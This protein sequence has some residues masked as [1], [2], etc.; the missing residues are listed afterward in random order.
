MISILL[1]GRND[2][3]GYNLHR[4][5]AL[6]LNCLAEVLTD[7]DDE[8]LFVDYGTPDELPT[9]VEALADTL[10]ER[11]L[12]L[13]HVVR[14]P[15]AL[16]TQRYGARTHLPLVEPVSRNTAARRA[17]SANR[18]LLSTNT[19]M[20]LLPLAGGSLSEIC[21]D[22][23]DG[24]YGLPRYELPEWLWEHLPRSD[25]VAAMAEIARLGPGLRLD[26][27]TLSHEWIRF[28]A[29]GDFQLILREDFNAIDGFDEEM[30]VGWHV[31]S[32]LS[33]RM[34]M[35]RGSIESLEEHLAGYH[36]NHNRIPTVYHGEE[37]P[38]NDLNRF[39]FSV[40]RS[41]V[42][43]QR[44]TW[45]LADVVIDDVKVRRRLTP[46]LSN[47]LLSAAG[48][49][50]SSRSSFDAREAKF[51]LEY[52]SGHVLPFVADALIVSPPDATIAY[53]GS[54]SVLER[55]L[56]SLVGELDLGRPLATARL[57]DLESVSELDRIADVLIV[58][59]GVDRTVGTVSLG[60]ANG[61][62]FAQ[63]RAGLI[64]S[65]DAFRRLVDLERARLGWGE[66]PRRFLLV[67]SSAVFWNAYV[68][69]HLDCSPTTPH[70]RVRHATVKL[71]PSHD[72][73]TRAA[74]VRALRLIRWMARRDVGQG[75]LRMRLGETLEIADIDDYAG[76]GDGWA[77]PEKEAVW[78]RGSRSEL[79]IAVDETCEGPCLLTLAFDEIGVPPEDPIH[80]DLLANGTRVAA[81]EFPRVRKERDPR[82]PGN[83]FRDVQRTL[84]KPIAK[85]VRKARALGVPGVDAAVGMA[86]RL[87]GG[88]A[89]D[90]TLT[91]N[92]ALPAHVL[93]DGK[94]DLTLVIEEPVSWSDDQRRGLHLRSLTIGEKS[95]RRR[96][97]GIRDTARATLRAHY[98]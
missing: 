91:W 78:T 31:D 53:I 59:L 57:E 72:D 55:M 71:R 25:P 74:N 84:R 37:T 92:I 7:P 60:T 90:P 10:T 94:V 63:A 1:Y 56:G 73:A 3:H 2:A 24:F 97:D 45:G 98:A 29:P 41:D 30:L 40:A 89:G 54:N 14:V 17:N 27:A 21:R 75:R 49:A 46:S 22:L 52:D 12:G 80:V 20:I 34:F 18:W 93:A 42:P 76:F 9:L 77:Y 85:L 70:S 65:F 43:A 4:R 5:V 32:N 95:R 87:V 86:R 48:D 19:D 51:A 62:E 50:P 8:I 82:R 33:R 83:D 6:S 38:A 39:F 79:S 36:C 69:A 44:E 13:V 66:H 81:C 35:R 58:D 16:H 64:R 23:P 88:Q 15:A 28:D 67:N 61:S 96:L 68:L 26:E 47:V 11:C